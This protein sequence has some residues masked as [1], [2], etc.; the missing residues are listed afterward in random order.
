MSS[1]KEHLHTSKMLSPLAAGL[2]F[3]AVHLLKT[4]APHPHPLLGAALAGIGCA[5]VGPIVSPDL[6]QESL[7]SS[8]W[9]VI[10]KFGVLGW[11][12]TLVW[13]PYALLIPHRNVFSHFPIVGTLGRMLYISL[14]FS[15]LRL[16]T[17]I[18]MQFFSWPIFYVWI[19]VALS[20]WAHYAQD[21]NEP[22][23][24]RHMARKR[25]D[26]YSFI[27]E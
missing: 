19:G 1:G 2:G 6:D 18:P 23:G 24:Y 9:S 10:R 16:V 5:F 4:V 26:Y 21:V 13:Y 8:E 15:L 22:R 20:D 11:A 3:G 25:M 27:H 17:G 7:T 14:I 12:Y